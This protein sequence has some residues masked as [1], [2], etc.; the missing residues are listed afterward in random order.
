MQ[1]KN[2]KHNMVGIYHYYKVNRKTNTKQA[3]KNPAKTSTRICSKHYKN[4][5]MDKIAPGLM[6]KV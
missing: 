1:S 4:R 3:N 6:K 2:I 5:E